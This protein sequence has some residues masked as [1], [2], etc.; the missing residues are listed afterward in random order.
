[1]S[2]AIRI[3]TYDLMVLSVDGV[4]Q[5]VA[6]FSKKPSVMEP[7]PVMSFSDTKVGLDFTALLSGK[8]AKKTPRKPLKGSK[9]SASKR[10]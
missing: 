9:R 4:I 5:S 10:N 1:M 7:N 2:G 6:I 3:G 8:A